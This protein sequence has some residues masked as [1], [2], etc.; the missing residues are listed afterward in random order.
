MVGNPAQ[1]S[2]TG[3]NLGIVGE[4]GLEPRHSQNRWKI[5]GW[6]LGM[7][8]EGMVCVYIYIYGS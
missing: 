7:I 1:T 8:L 3:N 2:W 4:T 6:V 5:G